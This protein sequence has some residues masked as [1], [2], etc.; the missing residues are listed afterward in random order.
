MHRPGHDHADELPLPLTTRRVLAVVAGVLALATAIGLVALRARESPR[1]RL[2]KLGLESTFYDARVETVDAD[3]T[4]ETG[5]EPGPEGTAEPPVRCPQAWVRLLEGPERGSTTLVD[6]PGGAAR[7]RFS[8][9]DKVVVAASPGPDGTTGYA[10][11]DRQRKPVLLWLA[12]GFA[13]VVVA[14]GR[15]R[16][17][18]ALAGLGASLGV[19]LAFVLPAIL[20]GHNPLLVAVV[21]SAAIAFLA[22]YLAH[23][24]RPATTVALLGTLAS[25]ALTAVLALLVTRLAALTGYAS[26]EATFV[27]LA[28]SSIDLRGLV[29][30]GV[31]IGAL[32]AID[33]MTVT[34]VAAVSELHR[35]NPRLRRRAL[36][37]SAMRIGRDHV[38]STVNTLALA[39]AGASIPLLLLFVLSDQSLGSVANGEVVATE[40]VRTLVG[41]IGLVSAVPITTWLAVRALPGPSLT[42]PTE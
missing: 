16:G 4:C 21:G 31:V 8:E 24:F 38:A 23:G 39:Y 34:Q 37:R 36:Y 3:R 42:P 7:V 30:A 28:Q 18:A 41:S 2:G 10:F 29:L 40:I 35:V 25:L 32:G 27:Q 13:L 1:D 17:V 26:E 15:L 22:L 9:G 12:V 11:V 33:D 20:V 5:G 14:L 6:L 19:L